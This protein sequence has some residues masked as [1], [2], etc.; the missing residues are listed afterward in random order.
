ME[1]SITVKIRWIFYVA[2]LIQHITNYF[3]EEK[4]KKGGKERREESEEGEEGKGKRS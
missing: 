1:L 2:F 3:K 4:A